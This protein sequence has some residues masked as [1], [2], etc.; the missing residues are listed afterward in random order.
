[1]AI[2][3]VATFESASRPGKFYT[4]TLADDGTPY[5]D[6]PPWKFQK[7]PADQRKDC[8]HIKEWIASVRNR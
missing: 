7:V 1:M 6:C 5:C 8:K 2:R 4:V 3:S